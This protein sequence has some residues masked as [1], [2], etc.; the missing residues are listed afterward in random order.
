MVFLDD[1]AKKLYY[2][3]SAL[4]NLVVQS[5]LHRV[6]KVNLKKLIESCNPL[7]LL[8]HLVW[9]GLVFLLFYLVKRTISFTWW[10]LN[11]KTTFRLLKV[12]NIEKSLQLLAYTRSNMTMWQ[13]DAFD[14]KFYFSHQL[15]H[16]FVLVYP[17]VLQL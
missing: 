15:N 3:P 10:I 16:P 4:I 5:I 9:R 1:F 11:T 14:V 6:Q 13:C 7:V 12:R 2:F 17:S 8:W